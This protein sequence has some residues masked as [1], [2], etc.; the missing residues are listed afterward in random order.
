MPI[1][2]Y[3][4]F[5]F[6]VDS[7][8]VVQILGDYSDSSATA[9]TSTTTTTSTSP[10]MHATPLLTLLS[11]LL[12]PPATP[13]APCSNAPAS[14]PFKRTALHYDHDYDYYQCLLLAAHD[15]DLQFTT[16]SSTTSYDARLTTYYLP[17]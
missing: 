8:K 5:A 14:P 17:R 12:P 10:D 2:L 7:Q 11:R 9:T 13:L 4:P 1:K 3:E 15:Y 6:S 16:Y